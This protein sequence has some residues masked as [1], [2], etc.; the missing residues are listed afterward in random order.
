MRIVASSRYAA[1]ILLTAG[2]ASCAGG[3]RRAVAENA[4]PDVRPRAQEV[5]PDTGESEQEARRR[6]SAEEARRKAQAEYE[7]YLSERREAEQRREVSRRAEEDRQKAEQRAI[8]AEEKRIADQ[9]LQE[10]KRLEAQKEREEAR[11]AKSIDAKEDATAD[12]DMA[13]FNRSMEAWKPSAMA[14]ARKDREEDRASEL[15]VTDIRSRKE[16]ETRKRKERNEKVDADR[17]LFFRLDSERRFPVKLEVDQASTHQVQLFKN[18]HP[19]QFM[20]YAADRRKIDVSPVGLPVVQEPIRLHLYD[21][22]KGRPGN[23]VL[24][25]GHGVPVLIAHGGARYRIVNIRS[26]GQTLLLV[27]LERE[28]L[29]EYHRIS[30]EGVDL[31]ME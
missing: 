2:L 9:K 16:S 1:I 29:S 5:A 3:S 11:A 31:M 30:V 22:L 8:Q 26:D 10:E 25:D 19:L 15:E 23:Y 14:A 13:I 21:V 6:R 20:A 17:S 7:A 28:D 24:L 18:R 4:G 12:R 27:D